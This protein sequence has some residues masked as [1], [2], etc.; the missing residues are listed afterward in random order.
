MSDAFDYFTA[1]ANSIGI[2]DASFIKWSYFWNLFNTHSDWNLEYNEGSGW[3]SCKEDLVIT[4]EHPI[5][6]DEVEDISKEKIT[7]DFTAS[8]TADYR[9]TFG[10]DTRVKDYVE[11]VD[12]YKYELN[13]KVGEHNGEDEIY[14][15]FF[16]W[17]DIA[18]IPGIILSHGIK[19][20]EGKDYFWFRAR[21]NNVTSGAHVVIDPTFGITTI[22]GYSSAAFD[23]DMILTNQAISPANDG[24]AT[25]ISLYC[26]KFS[27]Y[28]GNMCFAL[29]DSSDNSLV[30]QTEE[31]PITATEGWHTANFSS[32][33]TIYSA[34]SYYITFWLAPTKTYVWKKALANAGRYEL[35]VY[36]GT[37]PNDIGTWDVTDYGGQFCIYCSYDII[38]PSFSIDYGSSAANLTIPSRILE[39]TSNT[40]Q[41]LVFN[42]GTDVQLNRGKTGDSLT[43][44]GTEILDA[45]TLMNTLNTFM[46]SGVVVTLSGLPDINLN[47]DYRISN[48]DYDQML[49]E[50]CKYNI[51][52]ERVKD[53]L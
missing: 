48:F 43:L 42:D 34:K 25:S 22:I 27:S 2:K 10:I 37:Y 3:I 44:S 20:V 17:S 11:K 5:D 49:G 33:L 30:A 7:L 21:K 50:V 35:E 52:L 51:T 15:V 9:L 8:H 12:E 46:D 18:S 39:S 13:Y 24:T 53:K 47:T 31:I 45:L 19:E 40:I 16:D 4:K 38:I 6:E 1:P 32:P 41:N 29:Y 26:N 23:E 14:S 36:T 28:T